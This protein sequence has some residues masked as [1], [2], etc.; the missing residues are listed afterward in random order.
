MALILAG[1]LFLMTHMMGL[2]NV[3][4]ALRWILQVGTALRWVHVSSRCEEPLQEG[5]I[6]CSMRVN[7]M[8]PNSS[9]NVSVAECSSTGILAHP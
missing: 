9:D 7:L 3:W 4:C 6:T 2:I 5:P 1:W 8:L